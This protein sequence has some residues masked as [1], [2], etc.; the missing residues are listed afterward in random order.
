MAA[1]LSAY[2]LCGWR[3]YGDA[4]PRSR[5]HRQNFVLWETEKTT[6]LNKLWTE[7]KKQKQG[8]CKPSG[9]RWCRAAWWLCS[10]W[11]IQVWSWSSRNTDDWGDG[12]E[13]QSVRFDTTFK[14]KLF[15]AFLNLVS[16]NIVVL[17]TTNLVRALTSSDLSHFFM[18]LRRY[19]RNPDYKD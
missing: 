8:L 16:D 5:Q 14:F 17:Y 7:L 18:N 13:T 11:W 4:H 15:T 1:P 19:A 9:C 2:L 3:C 12:A 6:P 10:S